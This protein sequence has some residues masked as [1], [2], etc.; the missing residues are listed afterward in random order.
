M[1]P[2]AASRRA[3]G[4]L[5]ILVLAAGCGGFGEPAAVRLGARSLSVEDLR[6][7]WAD[8]DPQARPPLASREDR[9]VFARRVAH[10]L[11][12]LEEGERRLAGDEAPI[13][14]ELRGTL[15]R[16]LQVVL[17]GPADVDSA[18]V[19][20]AYARMRTR[21]L[22]RSFFFARPEEARA[23]LERLEAGAAPDG[24]SASRSEWV[25]WTPFPDPVADAIVDVPP[26]GLAGP[27]RTGGV[28]RV[29]RVEDRVDEDPG[30]LA[31]LRPRIVSGL[32]SR[33]ELRVVD[34]LGARLREAASVR[35]DPA[36][37]ATLVDRTAGAILAPR[38]A[39]QDPDW[40]VPVLA[41]GEDSLVV[42]SWDGGRLTAP[43][44]VR[45]VERASRSQ[46]PRVALSG[47][48]LRIV[49]AETT[50][51]LL[52]AE[53]RRRG[54]DQDPWVQRAVRRLRD[55]AAVQRAVTAITAG[56]E[57]SASVDSLAMLLLETQPGLF[58]REARARVLR[59]D[60]ADRRF[61]EEELARI[62][63]AGGPGR[64]LADL[65]RAPA[66]PPLGIHVFWM[67]AAELAA[68]S[69]A[70]ILSEGPGAVSGPHRG[71][72]LWVAFGCLD[73]EEAAEPTREDVLA[74]V[75]A[76]T[77][78]PDAARVEAWA[79]AR[80]GEEGFTIDEEILDALAPGG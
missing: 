63:D 9:R 75:R 49:E 39:E 17:A 14:R 78:G 42:V 26:G 23:A 52:A 68:A 74:Q 3:R 25:V 12:L 47:E 40:A 65:V 53:A 24:A 58:R 41:P 13:E 11:L 70:G 48:V 62:R 33:R 44:Y 37:V 56:A 69:A 18:K 27:V 55:D 20:A 5:A 77:G 31:G 32:R 54:L 21:A 29:L 51:S 64:R 4:A 45:L 19:A 76:R 28:W 35:V 34:E 16:R 36:A 67:T 59:I 22:V 60:A 10:R 6:A 80:A 1:N 50:G 73:I 38:A 57:T 72:D 46:R 8:L 71:G 15:V 66:P 79:D 61:V 7:A 2:T 30:P 43:E